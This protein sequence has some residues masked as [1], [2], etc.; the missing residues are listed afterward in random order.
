M[1]PNKSNKN[2]RIQACRFLTLLINQIVASCGRIALRQKTRHDNQKPSGF[3]EKLVQN[4]NFLPARNPPPDL[5]TA[6][7]LRTALK[8]TN[9]ALLATTSA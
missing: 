4:G 6:N 8:T 5:T 3:V 7:Q 9:L 1:R 2:N